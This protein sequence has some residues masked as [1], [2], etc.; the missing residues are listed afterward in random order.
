MFQIGGTSRGIDER[1]IREIRFHWAMAKEP[2]CAERAALVAV[3]QRATQAYSDAVT[4]LS[5]RM[6]TSSK[7][8]FEE[9]RRLS[10]TARR[11]SAEALKAL[12]GHIAQHNCA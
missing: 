8:E 2:E 3:Y 4:N 7:E 5:R 6:G 11:A 1:I 9:L 12:D 10:E